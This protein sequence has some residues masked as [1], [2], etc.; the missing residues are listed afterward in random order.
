M[1][2]HIAML[3]YIIT[4]DMLYHIAMLRYI[5]THDML[6]HIAGTAFPR[7]KVRSQ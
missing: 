7:Q 4:H 2:Y 3:R 1:L 6:Y 5:I